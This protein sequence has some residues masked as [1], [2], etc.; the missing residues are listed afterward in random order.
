MIRSNQRRKRRGGVVIEMALISCICFAFMFAIFE[1]GRV[2]MMQ[3]IMV[4]ASRAGARLAVITPTSYTNH[5]ADTNAVI[6]LVTDQ[7]A[8]LPLTQVNIQVY[9]ADDQGN[10]IGDWTTA[11]FGQN[12]VV[13]VDADCPNLFPT[14][15]PTGIPTSGEPSVMVNF[16]PN[17]STTTPNAVHL[18]AKTMMCSEAN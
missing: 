7:L 12:I 9:L 8:N 4:N 6:G 16:L 17:S 13:Q 10:N 2:V 18:T 3:Q 5:T 14:G 11:Q 1:Y 15:V